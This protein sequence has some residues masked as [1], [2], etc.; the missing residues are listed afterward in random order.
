MTALWCRDHEGSRAAA[1][2]IHSELDHLLG[3]RA[4]SGEHAGFALWPGRTGTVVGPGNHHNCT[5]D[6]LMLFQGM[7]ARRQWNSDEQILHISVYGVY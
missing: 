6:L 5:G 7:E 2:G 4:A 3:T 1:A